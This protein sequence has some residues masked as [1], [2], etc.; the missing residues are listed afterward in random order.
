MKNA[1]LR[2]VYTCIH[3]IHYAQLRVK[4]TVKTLIGIFY[5]QTKN[6][7]ALSYENPLFFFPAL[8]GRKFSIG[9]GS[10]AP[11]VVQFPNSR[12][13]LQTCGA[14]D[15]AERLYLIPSHDSYKN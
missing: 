15:S 1:I 8:P 11:L 14:M 13:Q 5:A 6:S 4:T 7:P 10:M 9:A 3:K 2:L 12:I